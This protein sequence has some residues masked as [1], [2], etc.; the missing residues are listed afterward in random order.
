MYCS[1]NCREIA[2][3]LYH[4]TECKILPFYN[5][6]DE[7][8]RK[9]IMAIRIFL[10]GT[11]QGTE[12]LEM[13]KLIMNNIFQEKVDPSSTPFVINYLSSLK[14][15]RT[16]DVSQI[17]EN[18]LAAIKVTILLQR[19]SF[20][21]TNSGG[22]HEDRVSFL[23]FFRRCFSGRGSAKCGVHFPEFSRYLLNLSLILVITFCL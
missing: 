17:Q 13:E 19:L 20:F 11:K 18:I 4:R 6:E 12:L 7:N 3:N 2:Y 8:S 9:V 16:F 22:Q 10:I 5:Y 15:C 1:R 14:L 21:E 23:F